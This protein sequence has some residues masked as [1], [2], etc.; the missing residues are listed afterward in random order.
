M[1]HALRLR[2]LVF[3]SP[4]RPAASVEFGPGFNLIYGASDTGKSFIVASIDFM[5]GGKGPL[6]D[7]PERVG[8]DR[9]LLGVE[10]LGGESFTLVRSTEGGA[11]KVFEGL[12]AEQ[13]EGVEGKELADQH[14][15]RN[16]D[17]ISAFLLSHLDLSQ[18]RIRKN[19]RADTQNLSFRNLARL[20]IVEEEEIIQKRSP[21]SDGNY[22]ADTA[23]T[24]VFK[25]LLTGLDDSALSA[26]KARTP[27]EQSRGA[28][29]DLLEQMIS[30]YRKQVKELAGPPVELEEQLDRLEQAMAGQSDQLAQ[31]EAS[32][33]EAAADRR[34]VLKKVED[35]RNRLT[36]ITA[37]LE[38][39]TLLDAHYRSDVVR[40]DAIKEAGNLFSGLGETT[41]PLCGAP[42][43]RH[44]S[45]ED[46][47][48]NVDAVV[49]AAAAEIAKIQVRQAELTETIASL[50]AEAVRFERRL[51]GLEGEV[52]SLSSRIEQIVAPNLR[53]LR[54]AYAELADKRGEVR[55]ALAVHRTLVD[56][57]ERKEK[58]ESQMAGSAGSSTSDVELSTTVVDEFASVVLDILKEWH[59]PHAERV[60]F[61]LSSRDLVING[62][63]RTSYGKGLR[64]ITQA[65]FTIALLEYCRNGGKPHPGFAVL[66]SPLLS[67]RE[68]ENESDDLSA[69]DL[70]PRFYDYLLKMPGDRQVIIV[71]NTEPPSGVKLATQAQEFTGTQATGRFGLFPADDRPAS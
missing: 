13:P 34:V 60:H 40:L 42:P 63:K 21:L 17:N 22:T 12:H 18:R 68:P 64:A 71:E 20:V 5:L 46:C 23:N 39:F 55:E 1:S 38:R 62:K 7:I 49:A 45:S 43:E 52:A 37:L 69:T 14:S 41:C 3:Q 11:F 19:K 26:G 51:P 56:L 16:S 70:K 44:R 57:E 58:L 8:Y 33:R 9:V 48:G 36:E 6:P 32:Y 61:D 50:R 24:A 31:T 67:Y 35:G 30:D 27:E 54:T 53:K 10:T 2:H 4:F 65:A 15:D 29:V 28:Q 47:D 59:F 66:D 25:L